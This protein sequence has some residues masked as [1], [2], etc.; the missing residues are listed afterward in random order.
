MK[1]IFLYIIS[2]MALVGCMNEETFIVDNPAVESYESFSAP[3]EISVGESQTKVF[4][5]ELKWSWGE[6]DKIY[7]YQVAGGKSVNTL[8]F[9]EDN[10]FGTPEFTYASEDAATFHFVY[11]GDATLDEAAD[12]NRGV[13]QDSRQSGEWRPVL[14]GSAV[15]KTISEVMNDEAEIDMEHL[16]AALEVRLWKEGVD[17]ANLADADKKN[18]VYAELMSDT[19]NF[20]LDVVPV[21][22]LDG[23]VSY[24]DRERGQ[25]EEDGGYIRTEYVNSPVAVFN[26]APHAENYQAGA[27]R[28][29]IVDEN[30]DRYVL[31]VPALNF[32]AGQRTILN[33]EWKTPTSAYLPDGPTFNSTVDA[34]MTGKGI[35]EI[36]FITNSATTSTDV[37]V[38]N[39]IYLVKNGETLEIHTAASQFVANSNCRNMFAGMEHNGN[40]AISGS[41][42]AFKQLK[43]IDFGENMNTQ[44]VTDMGSMFYYCRSLTSLDVSNFNTRNV[45]D[46]GCMFSDCS[47]LTS[48][49]LSNFD[50]QNVTGMGSMFWDC[51]SLT[52]LDL[53]NFDTQNVTDMTGMFHQCH[54]LTWLDVSNF[55]TQNV[56]DMRQ[57]FTRCSR[58]TWLDVSNFDTQNVTDM[59]EMFTDCS[60]LISLDVRNFDTQNVTDMSA[61]FGRCSS[62]STLDVSSFDTYNVTYMGSMF[63]GCS[64]LTWLDVSNFD[65]QNVTDI[66]QM[67]RGC[68]RLTS[69]GLSNF[70]TQNV[71]DMSYMFGNCSSLTSLDVSNFNTQNVTDMSYM[72]GNCSSLTSLDLSNFDTQNVTGM[73]SMFWDCSSLTSLDLSNFDTQNVTDIAQMFR[74]CSSLTSLDVSNFDTQNVTNMGSMFMGC[75]SLT[76][77][78]V[79]N[80]DT[81][82]VTNMFAMFDNCRILTSLDVSNFNTQNVTSMGDMFW[83]CTSLTSLDVSNFDTQKVTDM[84]EMF[85]DCTSLTSLDIS[86]FSFKAKPNIRCMMSTK[87]VAI[88]IYISLSGKSYIE[89]IDND[90]NPDNNTF[91]NGSYILVDETGGIVVPDMGDHG[92]EEWL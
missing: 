71:T 22:N 9:V 2:I 28:L 87:S 24:A 44:N 12:G 32:V 23:T 53:S 85:C 18:I 33:V 88:K 65:T 67:F 39:S 16:S 38:E 27:L 90:D 10:R 25:D 46:M 30:G 68:S 79:S 89:S 77:L 43:T 3:L 47:N 81:Q 83:G 72:F 75:T 66:A 11:A 57:M 1:K 19:E 91:F 73:G 49:D 41:D 61:M 84:S 82:N 78:D 92:D 86:T 52:S 54:H 4:D 55:N 58:L 5:G 45:T 31:D 40:T 29:A 7:G 36:K 59:C 21:Y 51:S 8:T 60:K 37:L 26:I 13:R 48:L 70:N 6:S 20:L 64:N 42:R 74:G 56:T 35:T 69:L 17:K 76:S 34:F 80:F 14:V 63:S 62:L 15:G 50:T